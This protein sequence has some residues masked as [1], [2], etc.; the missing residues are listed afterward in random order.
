MKLNQDSLAPLRLLKIYQDED[1]ARTLIENYKQMVSSVSDKIVEG[2]VR[3]DVMLDSH[4]H[5]A[6]LVLYSRYL[7]RIGAHLKNIT[8]TVVNAYDRIG[9]ES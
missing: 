8:S 1:L 4:S 5:S 9:Y 6:T 2:I 3:G 7:K